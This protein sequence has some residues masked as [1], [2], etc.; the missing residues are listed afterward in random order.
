MD[1][2]THFVPVGHTPKTLIDSLRRFPVAKVVFIIGD[3]PEQDSEKK[4]RQVVRDVK[5]ALGDLE[6]EQI[7]VNPEDITTSA[8]RIASEIN[9]Q[10]SR[11][12]KVR[13]NLSGSLRT[14]GAAAYIA[15]LVT[16]SEAYVGIPEY[17]DNGV[18]GIKT[19][20]GVPLIPVI[21]LSDKKRDILRCIKDSQISLDDIAS[22]LQPKLKKSSPG[23]L[24]EKSLISHHI[25]DLKEGKFVETDKDGRTLMVELTL[26]GKIYLQGCGE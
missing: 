11:G 10:K 12:K 17:K 14:I 8:L 9:K 5:K 3:K 24:N 7:E 16:N 21:Q 26:L 20:V 6:Y 15:A 4:A 23:Y 25:S 1:E 13:M 18:V 22:C 2:E 19:I